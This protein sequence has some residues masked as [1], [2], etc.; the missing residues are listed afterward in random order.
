MYIYTFSKQLFIY[1]YIYMYIFKATVH[2]YIYIYYNTQKIKS[3]K[4]W[5]T[6]RL[7]EDFTILEHVS[8]QGFVH[9]IYIV[10]TIHSCKQFWIYIHIYIYIYKQIVFP[11]V[12]EWFQTIP[13]RLTCS[14]IHSLIFNRK[15][16]T[17][18]R[19]QLVFCSHWLRKKQF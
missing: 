10:Y 6:R 11:W 12:F 9:Y 1:I 8:S 15:S 7:S 16:C 3:F 5:H 4:F 18:R 2:I 19:G 14:K 17:F 13:G